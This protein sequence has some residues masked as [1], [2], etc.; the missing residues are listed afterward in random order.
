MTTVTRDI[1]APAHQVFAV[2]ADGWTY[3]SWVVGASRIRHVDASF[4]EPGSAIHHSVGTWP[5]LI[6]D[7]TTVLA[8]E[9]GRRLELRVRAWPLGEGNV[10]LVL[11]DLGSST[12]VEM[13][14]YTVSGPAR[15]IPKPAEALGLKARNRE[16]LRRLAYLAEGRSR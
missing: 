7:T 2:L 11:R 1:D 16:A 9:P 3:A 13:E 10:A 15:L 14:E 5:A 6:D 12:T 8:C 4:P